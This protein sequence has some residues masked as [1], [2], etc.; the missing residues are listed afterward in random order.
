MGAPPQDPLPTP[1]LLEIQVQEYLAHE[2]APPPRTLQWTYAQ[3]PIAVLVGVRFLMSEV[4]LYGTLKV[5]KKWSPKFLSG[6]ELPVYPFRNTKP[7][8][9]V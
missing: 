1:P 9:N 8:D 7:R 4:P 5:I 6:L 2:K 3:C